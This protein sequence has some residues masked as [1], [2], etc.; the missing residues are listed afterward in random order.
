MPAKKSPTKKKKPAA[1]PVTPASDW[2]TTDQ[3]EI[4][5]R[6]QRAIDEKHSVVNLI[7]DNTLEHAMLETLA[8]KMTLA[9]KA[10]AE[11]LAIESVSA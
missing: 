6:V 3:D 2:R 5:R 7:A 8:N 10:L 9:E 4:L 1:I 11:A